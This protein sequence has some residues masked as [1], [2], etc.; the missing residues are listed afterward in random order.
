MK[1]NFCGCAVNSRCSLVTAFGPN[2]IFHI[3][4]STGQTNRD[5]N[6][7]CATFIEIIFIN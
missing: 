2:Y 7:V 6:I 1:T 4:S 5:G 3:K